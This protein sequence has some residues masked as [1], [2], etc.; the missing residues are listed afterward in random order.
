MEEGC[1]WTLA[2]EAFNASIRS[3]TDSGRWDRKPKERMPVFVSAYDCY[4]HRF[5]VIQVDGGDKKVGGAPA[6]SSTVP[7]PE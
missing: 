2:A 3:A 6:G 1:N 4:V 5:T 7:V